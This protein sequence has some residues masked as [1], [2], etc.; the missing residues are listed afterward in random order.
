[1]HHLIYSHK[2][3]KNALPKIKEVTLLKRCYNFLI[4]KFLM[5][6][7]TEDTQ[8]YAITYILITIGLIVKESQMRYQIYLTVIFIAVSRHVNR[9]KFPRFSSNTSDQL[10][11]LLI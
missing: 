3:N 9:F 1:M 10:R 7:K 2:R 5:N 4:N 8:T 6:L 11:Q